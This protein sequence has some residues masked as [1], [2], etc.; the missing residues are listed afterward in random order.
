MQHER[1]DDLGLLGRGGMGEVRRVRDRELG[2]LPDG[3]HYFT[4]AEV[5]GETMSAVIAALHAASGDG[6]WGVTPDGWTFR[7]LVDAFNRVCEAVAYAHTRGVIHRDLKPDNIMLDAHGAVQVL[8]WGL[9]RV[10]DSAPVSEP[11]V[12]ER[13][14]D[15]AQATR[16]GVVAGTPA[17]MSPEQARGETD[18]IDARSDIY[19]LGAILYEL[20]AGLPPYTGGTAQT[21]LEWVR[22]G[23]PAPLGRPADSGERSG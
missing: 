19:A 21:V 8:D 7:R 18:R 10:G 20:L 13:Q 1:Y 23:P 6:R 5:R 11:I 3:R 2:T 16:V 17:Y 14:T 4:M 12:T 15:S 9:A 22:T